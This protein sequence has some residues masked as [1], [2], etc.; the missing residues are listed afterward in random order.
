MDLLV[1]QVK[2]LSDHFLA[3]SWRLGLQGHMLTQR[4]CEVRPRCCLGVLAPVWFPKGGG[5]TSGS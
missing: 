2:D 3:L 4:L 1:R 5:L